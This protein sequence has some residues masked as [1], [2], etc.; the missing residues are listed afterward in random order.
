MSEGTKRLC[1]NC[2]HYAICRGF[3]EEF[4]IPKDIIG[5]AS[6]ERCPDYVDAADV[7]VASRKPYTPPTIEVVPITNEMHLHSLGSEVLAAFLVEFESGSF[8]KGDPR[9]E[10]DLEEDHLIPVERC[11]ECALA[12]LKAPYVPKEAADA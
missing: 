4:N 7:V 11:H 1:E 8:C 12:W 6:A 9:C 3:A 2:F 10:A 5:L